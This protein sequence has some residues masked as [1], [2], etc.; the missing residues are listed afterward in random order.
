MIAFFETLNRINPALC[1][2]LSLNESQDNH[3]WAGDIVTYPSRSG[4]GNE[5]GF[6]LAGFESFKD[7]DEIRT[8]TDGMIPVA[9]VKSVKRP[10][11]KAVTS[12][13]ATWYYSEDRGCNATDKYE[14]IQMLRKAIDD[15]YITSNI[16]NMKN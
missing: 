16:I 9:E 13:L 10:K 3:I 6:V 12:L 4:S 14:I 1:E 11:N 8:D 15:G 2:S 7:D 5:T